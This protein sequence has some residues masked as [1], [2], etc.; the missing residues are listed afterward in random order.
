M[1]SKLF[2]ENF[3]PP[4]LRILATGQWNLVVAL[5]LGSWPKLLKYRGRGMSGILSRE[6]WRWERSIISRHLSFVAG[7]RRCVVR[8]QGAPNPLHTSVFYFQV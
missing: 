8:E 5:I 1:A 2:T 3:M 6:V 4:K 7:E